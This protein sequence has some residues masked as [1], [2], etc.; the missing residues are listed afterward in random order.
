MVADA[1]AA[2][3]I[4][5]AVPTPLPLAGVKVADFSWIGVGP[6]T[7]KAL[8][9]HG[10][11]VVHVEHDRPADRLRLVG[12]FKDDVPGINRCQFFG[13]FNTSKLSLQ[14]EPQAPR[15]A[16]TSPA[17]CWRGATSP[18]TRSPPARWPSSAWATR[19]PAS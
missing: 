4:A 12:P 2:P 9:D 11:T 14:L 5:V 13:S 10:A 19:W 17:S 16:T 6:I 18:S 8:A 7:A 3:T 15:R 1:D